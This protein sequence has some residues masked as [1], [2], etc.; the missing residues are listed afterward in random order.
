MALRRRGKE[1]FYHAYFRTVV[2]LPDGRL[3]YAMT[4]VNLG[5]TD[6]VTARALEAELLK[7]NKAV[8]LY[9]RANAR[10]IQMEIAAGARPA[11]GAEGE[12]P[13]HE[14]RKKRLQ[15][16]DW[17]EAI[18]QYR[19]ISKDSAKIFNRFVER[20]GLKYFDEV[21][22][23]SALAYL[24][25]NYGGSGKGKSFNNNKTA[26]NTIFRYLLIDAGMSESPFSR[27]PN[28]KHRANHQRPF[29]EEEF[30][31]IYE[32]A[33]EPWKTASLIAWYT[34]LREES[35]FNMRWSF[36]DGDVL[37]I[38]P[39]KTARYGR[40][41][42]IPL[43]PEVQRRLLE[44]PKVNDFVL[45]CF[46]YNRETSSFRR[47]FGLL[48]DSLGIVSGPEGLVN[49]NCFRDSFIT[50]CDEAGI[51]RHATRGVVGHVKDETTDLYS[52]DLK[53]ARL[54]QNLPSVKLDK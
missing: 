1:N 12:V 54:I 44:L 11:D 32:A 42:R 38:M 49:F 45:G 16:K 5:T 34:G 39:G 19:T 41:V 14:H 15:L 25:S 8:R 2:S 30:I 51:P 23:E 43:H 4:T 29:T 47:S 50:R 33:Q 21:T 35:V 7:K 40:A 10:R 26:L 22:P 53:T 37:T 17:Q 6:L 20:C 13:I 31:R 46:R 3:K 27:I 24:Q 28:R 48:L 36:I 52:H 9:Q 18:E